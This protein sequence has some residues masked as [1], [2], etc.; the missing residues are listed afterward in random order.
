[1]SI[2]ERD[3]IL[4]MIRQLGEAIA[5]VAGLRRQGRTDEASL[6]LQ[7]TADGVLG[8]MSSMIDRLD[9]ASAAML[10]GSKPKIRAY[11]SILEERAHIAQARSDESASRTARLRALELWLRSAADERP[12][13]DEVRDHAIALS[14]SADLSRLSTQARAVLDSIGE[15]P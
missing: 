13:P 3:V 6:L 2:Q 11:A 4:R 8:P 1:M 7:Q 12:V 14:G 5:R 9:A 10:L 15:P